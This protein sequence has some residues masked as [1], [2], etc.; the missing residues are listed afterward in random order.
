MRLIPSPAMSLWLPGQSDPHGAWRVSATSLTVAATAEAHQSR[1]SRSLS[2]SMVGQ[3]SGRASIRPGVCAPRSAKLQTPQ[4]DSYSDTWP[5]NGFRVR[6]GG[7]GKV[8][9]VADSDQTSGRPP[10]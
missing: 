7:T 2:A 9:P 5:A 4:L 3:L 1:Q 8:G 10:S 6:P